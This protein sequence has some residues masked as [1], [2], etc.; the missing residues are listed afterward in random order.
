V[1]VRVKLP[2]LQ[3]TE[4]AYASPVPTRHGEISATFG[5]CQRAINSSRR[6]LDTLASINLVRPNILRAS[7][8]LYAEKL[9]CFARLWSAS[10][11][12]SFS[13]L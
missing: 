10:C 11:G 8:N 7:W 3:T 5:P 6:L 9:W 4:V 1:R 12:D 13:I 2:R